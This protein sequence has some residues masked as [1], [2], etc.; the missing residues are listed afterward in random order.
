MTCGPE[1]ALRNWKTVHCE[2]EIHSQH[3]EVDLK[4]KG[5]VHPRTHHEGRGEGEGLMY[6]STLSLTLALHGSGWS[7]PHFSCFNP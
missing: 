5:K 1:V 4:G 7:T 6:S 3:S 2:T